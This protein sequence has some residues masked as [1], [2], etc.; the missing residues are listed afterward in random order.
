MLREQVHHEEAIAAAA[1]ALATSHGL[2]QR[3]AN[4][5]LLCA[6]IRARD[7]EVTKRLEAER[8]RRVIG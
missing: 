7:P 3:R 1:R 2:E 5:D 6:L 8:M 4:A